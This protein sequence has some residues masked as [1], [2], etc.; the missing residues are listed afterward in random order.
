MAIPLLNKVRCDVDIYDSQSISNIEVTLKSKVQIKSL[1]INLL[2]VEI[3][4]ISMSSFT[5]LPI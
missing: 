3:R 5:L 4:T 2:P 1:F